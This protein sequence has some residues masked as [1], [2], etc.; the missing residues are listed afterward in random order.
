MPHR[1]L[2][3][4]ALILIVGTIVGLSMGRAQSMGLYLAPVPKELGVGRESFGLGSALA[5]L[6]M[7]FG[8]PCSGALIDE[9]GAWRI[10]VVCVLTAIGGLYVLYAADSGI[11]L[12]LIGVL[13]GVGVSG[14]GI[15][16]LV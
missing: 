14:T 16:S 4:W 8:A 11:D 13:M 10:I 15:T 7:G 6:A 2:P 3:L 1:A 12:L 9:F 5:E